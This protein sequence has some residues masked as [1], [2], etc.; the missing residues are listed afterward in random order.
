MI[1]RNLYRR[2]DEKFEAAGTG[3]AITHGASGKGLSYAD[4]RQ[5]AARYAA[6]LDGAGVKP[7]DRVTVQVEKSAANVL[8]LLGVLKCGAVYQPLNPAYTPTEVEYF[9][10]DAKPALVVCDPAR[11]AAIGQI[12]ARHGARILTLDARGEGSHAAAAAASA[13][14]HRTVERAGDDIAG[15]LYTSGTT[16]RSKGAMITH[17]N[18]SSNML[19]LHAIWGFR[20]GDV[21]LHA[22][23]IF[24]VH[25]LF[26]ALGTAFLNG[27]EM[28]WHDKFDT[29]RVL[30]DL[31]S[32]TVFMGVP[33]FYTRLLSRDG[34]TSAACRTVRLFVSGSAP[35]LTE[36]HREFEQRTGHKVLERYGMTE[37]GMITSNP[38]VGERVAGTVGY[39]LPRV[40]VRVADPAGEALPHG[41]IGVIEVK[42]PNVF[43]GYWG[44]PEKTKEEIRPDGWF[45]TGDLGVMAEDGRVSIVGRAK[46]LIISGG[47]NVYPK[48]IEDAVDA[49][50]GVVESAVIGVPH[51]DFGE[52]VVAVVTGSPPREEEMLSAL[53]TKLANFKLPKRIFVV[54]ELPRNTMGKV[55]KAELRKQYGDTF[56]A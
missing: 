28:L 4:L 21:L 55:Q 49:I 9:V 32:A 35:L 54:A 44:M 38:Y 31:P 5:G 36:T 8:L 12:A 45:I 3:P 37:T 47:F 25:G 26:V 34:L 16:G 46:D 27:S 51:P 39:P 10:G 2:F 17:D 43:K 20:P 42:G 13:P 30:A 11:E 14:L 29:D 19:A 53:R 24:H 41:E 15:L 33:T 18:L 6:A 50:P 1:D 23:P 7:G 48:E 40:S 22:L 52:G 56:R